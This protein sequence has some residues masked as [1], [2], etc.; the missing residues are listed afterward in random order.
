MQSTCFYLLFSTG[1]VLT[2]FSVNFWSTSHCQPTVGNVL[3]T[4]WLTVGRQVTDSRKKGEPSFTLTHISTTSSE[5]D[6]SYS[7]TYLVIVTMKSA[8]YSVISILTQ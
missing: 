6:A 8:D 7:V 5:S 3:V 4:C 1:K 2:L